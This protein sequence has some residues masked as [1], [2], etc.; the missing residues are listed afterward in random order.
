MRKS[1]YCVILAF[2]LCSSAYAQS[3]ATVTANPVS[4]SSATAGTNTGANQQAITFNSTTPSNISETVSGHQSV[5]TTPSV[6]GPQ[7]ITSNDTCMGS[8]SGSMNVTGFGFGLGKTYTDH[9][10]VLLKDSR[11]LWNMGQQRASLAVMCNV[12]EVRQAFI[13]SYV[14][15]AYL[16][17]GDKPPKLVAVNNTMVIM[18]S[19]T[20]K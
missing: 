16:C 1:K 15:G 8:A 4:Q 13:D 11:Q 17:P 12:P 10:C 2:A 7:L 18:P 9:N 14:P 6:S 3:D 5:S 19:P 20:S